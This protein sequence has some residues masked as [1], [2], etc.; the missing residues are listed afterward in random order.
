M[1]SELTGAHPPWP[2]AGLIDLSRIAM[3][4]HSAGGA[5]AI[6]A[7]LTD[8]RIRAGIDMD[9]TLLI[10]VR[11]A[12]ELS[13]GASMGGPALA[14]PPLAAPA[15]AAPGCHVYWHE[16]DPARSRRICRPAPVTTKAGSAIAVRSRVSSAQLTVSIVRAAQIRAAGRPPP[17]LADA[18][19]DPR[20]DR[21]G[22]ATR[23]VVDDPSASSPSRRCRPKRR[24]LFPAGCA[25]LPGGNPPA[26]DGR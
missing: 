9:G 13:T 1:L 15:S 20:R 23:A 8:P 4:G 16:H 26:E 12:A 11:N 2:G 25:R 17:A 21:R 10:P 3:A 19:G 18:A 6:P 22:H 14:N 7:M 5:A 24:A